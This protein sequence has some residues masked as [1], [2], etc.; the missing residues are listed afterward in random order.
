M[1][2]E[3]ERPDLERQGSGKTGSGW[4]G[5]KL[6]GVLA[7]PWEENRQ[8]PSR[9]CHVGCKMAA[10][11]ML[12]WACGS[13]SHRSAQTSLQVSEPAGECQ[14]DTPTGKNPGPSSQKTQRSFQPPSGGA[15]A[16]RVGA[17]CYPRKAQQET[18]EVIFEIFY[19]CPK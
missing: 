10:A 6:H 18:G 2:F 14:V 4:G 12:S 5:N 11:W 19:L 16:V 9:N 15:P 8:P 3:P 7:V 1:P 13:Q 17:S